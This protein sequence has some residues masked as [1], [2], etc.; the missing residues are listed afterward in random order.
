MAWVNPP[1]PV[2]A[3]GITATWGQDVANDLAIIGGAWTYFVPGWAS[4]G[5]PPGLGN[6]TLSGYSNITGKTVDYF[7]RL[8]IGSTTAQ[9]TGDWL[10]GVPATL[11]SVYQTLSPIGAGHILSTTNLG[12]FVVMGTGATNLRCLTPAGAYVGTGSPAAFSAGGIVEFT[13]RYQSA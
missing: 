13:V 10:F 5:T 7:F 12:V 3:T 4:T 8:T 11:S 2:T 6:G 1:V 9:G